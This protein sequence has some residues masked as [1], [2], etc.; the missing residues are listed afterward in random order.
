[1]SHIRTDG[2]YK[3]DPIA[4]EEHHGGGHWSGVSVQFWRFLPVG[5]WLRCISENHEMPFWQ[6]SEEK[7]HISDGLPVKEQIHGGRYTVSDN[8]LRIVE[9]P[10]FIEP[11]T[12]IWEITQTKLVPEKSGLPGHVEL[13][14]FAAQNGHS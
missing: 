10:A 4:W 13:T 8:R 1:M 11:A 14:F 2:V 7:E 5:R 6:L 3:S 9:A 12:Y